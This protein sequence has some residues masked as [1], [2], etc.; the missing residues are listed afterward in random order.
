VNVDLPISYHPSSSGKKAVA[1]PATPAIARRAGYD[2]LD[3]VIPQ[4]ASEDPARVRDALDRAGVVAGPASLPMEFRRGHDEF[5]AGLAALPRL[6]RIAA[7]VGVT[8]MFRSIPAS[9]DLRPSELATLMRRRIADIADVLSAEGLTFAVEVL[10]PLHRRR[11]GRHE[12]IWRL[13]DAA[14]LVAGCPANIGLLADAWHWH[15]AG[16]TP[17][18]LLAVGSLI[19]HVHVADSPPLAAELIRDNERVLPGEGVIDLPSFYGALQQA[20]YSGFVSPE[21]TGYVCEADPASCARR[22]Y[23]ATRATMAVR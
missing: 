15:H 13:T 20:G 23:D 11:E 6:A 10:G 3:I 4:I 18:D 21:I 16:E 17:D 5:A 14:D 19:H 22:V 12:F 7:E 2:A 8:T 1:W 9:T